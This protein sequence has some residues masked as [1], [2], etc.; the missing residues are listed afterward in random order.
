MRRHPL[1][2]PHVELAVPPPPGARL[3]GH[4]G[5]RAPNLAPAVA[6]H[7]DSGGGRARRGR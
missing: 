2:L 1:D 6:G 4:G 7:G 3:A 5:H